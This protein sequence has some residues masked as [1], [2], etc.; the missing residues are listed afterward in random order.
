MRNELS[1]LT[2]LDLEESLLKTVVIFPEL[3]NQAKDLIPDAAVFYSTPYRVIWT[4]LCNLSSAKE[5]ATYGSLEL[6]QLLLH[7]IRGHA[8]SE[9]FE[10]SQILTALMDRSSAAPMSLEQ[11]CSK[12][13]DVFH[14]RKTVEVLSA[15][16]G[17][18][19]EMKDLGDV[20]DALESELY[21]LQ[22]QRSGVEKDWR[23]R[24]GETAQEDYKGEIEA[25]LSAPDVSIKTGLIDFD[26]VTMG[27]RPGELSIIAARPSMGKSALAGYIANAIAQQNRPVVFF[28]MEMTP[29][30]LDLRRCSLLSKINGRKFLKKNL[31]SWE[32]AAAVEVWQEM[33]QTPLF[34]DGNPRSTV[35]SIRSTLRHYAATH[36]QLGAFVVDYLQLMGS[37]DANRNNEI[38]LI[39]KE[40]KALAIEFKTHCIC[41]SQLSRS[42][43][44]RQNKRPILSDLR[45]SGGIEQNA[46]VVVLL[47]RDEYYNPQSCD[48]GI[49]ELIVMKNRKAT[50]GTV[51][52]LTQLEYSNYENLASLER[53]D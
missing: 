27:L 2:S 3:L 12:L 49:T 38:E 1:A 11:V 33:K 26:A 6:E 22:Q 48:R 36:G 40:L 34:Y 29:L 17:D 21:R 53:M 46:D 30:D 4:E 7:Q 47:Y 28:S 8:T 10:Y 23:V 20:L 42:V 39:T 9:A 24:S 5:S 13:V 16:L 52:V 14:R 15:A 44:S 31:E 50:V 43:E 19:T 41:L 45:D 51:K 18:V 35:S 32:R 25:Y 37:G